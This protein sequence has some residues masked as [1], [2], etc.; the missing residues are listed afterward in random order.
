MV[1]GFTTTC[2]INVY[3]HLSCEFELC[4]WQSVLDTT[5]CD[6]VCQLLGQVSGFLQVLDHHDITE[7]LLK[8]VLN[9][10]NQTFILSIIIVTSRLNR[11][12]Q[13]GQVIKN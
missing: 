6:R 13:T 9:T 12:K 4:S 3:H 7:I 10:I 8:V 2:A 1:V 5:L 11:G